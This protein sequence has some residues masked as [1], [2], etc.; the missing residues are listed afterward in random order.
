MSVPVRFSTR[1]GGVGS[2]GSPS[3]FAGAVP[4]THAPEPLHVLIPLQTRASSHDVPAGAF[5]CEMVPGALPL[6]TSVVHGVPSS[7]VVA[8]LEMLS[9][10]LANEEP[11]TLPES[12][13]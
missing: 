7:T 10:P 12:C 4:A 1:R 5:E 9:V 3:S 8:R 13:V 6:H 11:L 2:A